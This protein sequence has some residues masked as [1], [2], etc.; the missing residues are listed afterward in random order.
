MKA[1]HNEKKPRQGEITAPQAHGKG[2]QSVIFSS[3]YVFMCWV[4]EMSFGLYHTEPYK[5]LCLVLPGVVMVRHLGYGWL[6]LEYRP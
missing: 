5:C 1:P 6:G 2:R 4:L 3:F